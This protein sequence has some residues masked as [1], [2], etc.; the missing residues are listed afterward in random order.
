[1]QF[2]LPGRRR[3]AL[4]VATHRSE[5]RLQRLELETP[6]ADNQ[7]L[8]LGNPIEK[9]HSKWQGRKDSNPLPSVLEFLASILPASTGAA[10]ELEESIEVD[11]S[12]PGWLYGWLYKPV[13]VELPG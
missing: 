2:P 12:R 5:A 10:N 4:S 13:C 11:G 9:P 3:P 7:Q 1:M 8:R 6:G